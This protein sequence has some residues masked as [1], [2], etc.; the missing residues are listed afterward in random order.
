MT[1]KRTHQLKPQARNGKPLMSQLL[2]DTRKYIEQAEQ[3]DVELLRQFFFND[4]EMPLIAM[5][6]GGSHPSA[7]YAA[8]LYGTNCGLGRAV[9][10]YQANSLSDKTLQ[11]AKL[12]LISKS[13]M[14]QDAVYISQRMARTNPEHSC[15]LTMTH[16]DNANMKRMQKS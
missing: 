11:T 4:P 15:V 8:L 6:H 7:A 2:N 5:G 12:L 9:T 10:P 13:L 1:A 3:T 14:N 16:A